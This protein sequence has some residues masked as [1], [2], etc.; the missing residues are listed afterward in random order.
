MT[1]LRQLV[2]HDLFAPLVRRSLVQFQGVDGH[3]VDFVGGV[4]F[5]G[6]PRRLRGSTFAT[7]RTRPLPS[8]GDRRRLSGPPILGTRRS[9]R[10]LLRS[11]YTCRSPSRPWWCRGLL[12]DSKRGSGDICR[13]ASPAIGCGPSRAKGASCSSSVFAR[14]DDFV[15]AILLAQPL[16]VRV[17]PHVGEG[18]RAV[19]ELGLVEFCPLEGGEALGVF[20]NIGFERDG[21]ERW[22]LVGRVGFEDGAPLHKAPGPL[23][24]GASFPS[25]PSA[26]IKGRRRTRAQL[27]V[28]LGPLRL[29]H[30]RFQ[31]QAANTHPRSDAA[32]TV[33][34]GEVDDWR[35]ERPLGRMSLDA[36]PHQIFAFNGAGLR[37]RCLG[38]KSCRRQSCGS[39]GLRARRLGRPERG[40]CVARRCAR[41]RIRWC[42]L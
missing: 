24:G 30:P 14:G 34:V 23:Q 10:T 37:P 18:V 8:S 36:Q 3:A 40:R 41:T 31:V 42:L 32:T 7:L 21:L 27:K 15:E 17:Q 28:Y 11:G 33:F 20:L 5:A 6:R 29:T 38:A 1:L 4:E 22:G 39:N 16:L 19:H 35:A 26:R 9:R 12:G 2:G 13:I 25:R